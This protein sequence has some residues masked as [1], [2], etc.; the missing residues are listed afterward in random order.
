MY[1]GL[2]SVEL[3]CLAGDELNVI[4]LIKSEKSDLCAQPNLEKVG[5]EA[6][7][8]SFCKSVCVNELI[9]IKTQQ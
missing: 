7:P 3:R 9:I 5:S 6:P 4:E 8:K 1:V 2:S